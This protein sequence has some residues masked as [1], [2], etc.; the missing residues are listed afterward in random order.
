MTVSK[1][2][3]RNGWL[4]SWSM[5]LWLVVA[6]SSR[7]GA[8]LSNFSYIQPKPKLKPKRKWFKRKGRLYNGT[9]LK[10]TTILSVKIK[11]YCFVDFGREK[12]LFLNNKAKNASCFSL[13]LFHFFLFLETNMCSKC[14]CSKGVGSPSK[15]IAIVVLGESPSPIRFSRG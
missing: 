2:N 11:N 5:G 10:Q 12:P 14:L 4:G 7:L 8:I 6:P 13:L 3:S 15:E 1:P 9:N